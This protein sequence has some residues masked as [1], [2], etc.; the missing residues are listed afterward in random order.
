MAIATLLPNIKPL[1]V[2]RRTFTPAAGAS[3][4][5]YAAGTSTPQTTY[6]DS[7]LT[8]PNTNPIVLTMAGESANSIYLSATGYKATLVASDGVTLWTVDNFE[9]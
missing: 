5:F 4:Y 7:L 9:T 8:V 6:S 2:D 3:L 1:F